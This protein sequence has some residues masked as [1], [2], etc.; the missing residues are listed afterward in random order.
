[1]R[2]FALT[3]FLLFTLLFHLPIAAKQVS[4]A[5]G[6]NKP[7]YVV[8]DG[9]S[10]FE[11]ELIKHFMHNEGHTVEFIFIPFG[12]TSYILNQGEADIGLTLNH[13]HDI[14]HSWLSDPYIAYQNFAISLIRNDVKVTSMADLQF[15]SVVAFQSATTVLGPEYKAMVIGRANYLELPDQENQ[16]LLLLRGSVDIAVMDRNIFHFFKQH[17]PTYLRDEPIR[18]HRL[19]PKSIYSAG[20]ADDELREAFNRQLKLA[21]EDGTYQMLIQQ[22]GLVDLLHSDVE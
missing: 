21:I 1:M 7:P 6:K 9:S 18:Y 22:F 8:Q 17:S 10:G 15:H 20:I 5:V 3:A 19:F 4:V 12:R 11:L 13:Y 2:P 16:V 14:D